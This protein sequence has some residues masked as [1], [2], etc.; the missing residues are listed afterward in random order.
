MPGDEGINFTVITCDCCD[1]A[2]CVFD[3]I[4]TEQNKGTARSNKTFGSLIENVADF[5]DDLTQALS[6]P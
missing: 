6:G 4:F 1:F 3:K 5:R 2:T